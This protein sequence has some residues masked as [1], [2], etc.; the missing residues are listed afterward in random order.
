MVIVVTIT[1]EDQTLQPQ[2]PRLSQD[3][4]AAKR[5]P[6]FNEMHDDKFCLLTPTL[7]ERELR[8]L[9]KYTCTL[10]LCPS[11]SQNQ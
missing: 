6:N 3:T 4:I 2:V 9:R 7:F 1:L 10:E 5:F 8:K 11:L